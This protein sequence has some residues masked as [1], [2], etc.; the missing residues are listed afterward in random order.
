MSVLMSNN[1][2]YKFIY[3]STCLK[4]HKFCSLAQYNLNILS[5]LKLKINPFYK[6]GLYQPKKIVFELAF[7]NQ[8]KKIYFK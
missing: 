2:I 4:L 6:S 1:K 8:M 3:G 5:E 7:F